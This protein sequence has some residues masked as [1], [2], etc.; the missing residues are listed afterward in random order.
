MISVIIPSR[1]RPNELLA[2]LN[3]LGLA[4]HRL[5]VLV[6]L[7]SDDPKLEKYQELFGSNPNIKLFVKERVGYKN[8]HLMLNFLA[9][10]VLFDWIFQWNDDA[11]MTNPDWFQIFEDFVKQFD[12]VNQPVVINIWGQGEIV[13]NL[14]PI[15]SRAYLD[16]LGHYSGATTCDD[17]VR[18]VA[19]GANIAYDLK[20]IKP[21]HRKYGG[22]DPLRDKTFQEVERDR[23]EVKKVWNERRKILPKHRLDADINKLIQCNNDYKTTQ[24][25][26]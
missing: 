14:F 25:P 20:G 9:S 19:I 12:P 3:S 15:V 22:E 10:Q 8:S 13:N 11:I 2:A 4:K 24:K 16:T 21:K 26:S 18:M 1:D 6:W 5:E 17:W 23:V 7:D